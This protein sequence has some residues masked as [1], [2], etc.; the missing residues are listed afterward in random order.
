[1]STDSTRERPFGLAGLA[2]GLRRAAASMLQTVPFPGLSRRRSHLILLAHI[3][4]LGTRL[5]GIEAALQ[6]ETEERRQ[7]MT[8]N[9]RIFEALDKQGPLPISLFRLQ[10][11]SLPDCSAWLTETR[12]SEISALLRKNAASDGL[13]HIQDDRH[14]LD[15]VEA[16][17]SALEGLVTARHHIPER[18]TLLWLLPQTSVDV[19]SD[20]ELVQAIGLLGGQAEVHRSVGQDKLTAVTAVR[21]AERLVPIARWTAATLERARQISCQP[22]T[23]ASHPSSF[24]SPAIVLVPHD[25]HDAARAWAALVMG[26][27]LALNPSTMSSHG[28]REWGV[29]WPRAAVLDPAPFARSL[30]ALREQLKVQGCRLTFQWVNGVPS[31]AESSKIQWLAKQANVRLDITPTVRSQMAAAFAAYDDRE[32]YRPMA[33]DLRTPSFATTAPNDADL[34]C[35]PRHDTVPVSFESD[36]YGDIVRER[37]RRLAK[38]LDRKHTQAFQ[39]AVSHGQE[40]AAA[41]E[42][43]YIYNWKPPEEFWA[44]AVVVEG[45]ASAVAPLIAHGRHLSPT[46]LLARTADFVSV[47]SLAFD[48]NVDLQI[49]SHGYLATERLEPSA[50]SARLALWLPQDLGDTL[51]IGSGFGVLAKTFIDR[52]RRYWGLDLTKEQA[53]AIEALGGTGVLGDIHQLPFRDAQLDTVIGDNVVEHALDPWRVLCEVRRVLK[54]GGRAYFVIPLDYLGP[55]YRNECHHWKADD[56]SIR[57]ALDLAG[58]E[59]VRSEICILPEIGSYGSFPSCD[60]RTSLW[61]VKRPSDLSTGPTETS[62]RIQRVEIGGAK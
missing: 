13:I 30:E 57:A 8:M 12:A 37:A 46:Q 14:A 4:E 7:Q 15:P 41:W 44:R 49:R 1:M 10:F 25:D 43:H 40:P 42:H 28:S 3:A 35:L 11:L 47:G 52:T 21:R 51:E 31:I 62:Q 58:L 23:S 5:D 2:D 29:V 45:A 6:T 39:F 22:S 19:L 61:E 27:W 60:Q 26:H 34:I 16:V 55:D 48:G 20:D 33:F 53:A 54:P 9:Q 24:C 38:V 32:P 56:R 59:I 17:R 36:L 50:D 18:A